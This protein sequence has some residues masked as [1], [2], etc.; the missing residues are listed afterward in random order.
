MAD[1]KGHF[2]S[3]QTPGQGISRAFLTPRQIQY[4]GFER[5]ILRKS[6]DMIR[7]EVRI[8]CLVFLY[9]L[10]ACISMPLMESNKC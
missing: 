4:G 8:L 1:F 6:G 5:A 9:V 10:H 7:D 2:D 3:S